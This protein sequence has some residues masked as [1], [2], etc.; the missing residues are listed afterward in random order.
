MW[1]H[2]HD[3]LANAGSLMATTV[4]TSGLGF[5]FWTFA[6]REFSQQAVGYGSAAV[7]AM[8]LLGTIGV[9]GLG[10]V[11]IGEL[12]R[13][14]P[15]AGL[16]SAALLTCGL[17]SVLLGIGFAMVAPLVSRRFGDMMGT[18]VQALLF[19]IGVALTAV[20]SV[21]D[22]ATIGLLRGGVQLARNL[23]FAAAKLLALPVAA[24]ILHDQFGIGISIS[25]VAGMAASLAASAIWLRIRGSPVLPR[26][27]WGVL[28]GLGKTAL[29]HNWLNLAIAVPPTL[30]PV[31]VTVVVSPTAN[32][33]FYVAWLLTGFLYAVPGN[34]ATVLFAV[35]AAEPHMISQK[36]RFAVKLSLLIGVPAMFAEFLG[37]HFVLSL[38]GIGYAQEATFPL[39]LLALAYLPT[40]PKT[41]YIAVCRAAGKVSR[42]AVVLTTFAA[43]ELIAAGVGGKVGG[44]KGLTVAIFAIVVIEGLVTTPAVLRSAS[45]RDRRRR[46][47][48]GT[49]A[50]IDSSAEEGGPDERRS[51]R[52]G[53]LK[54]Q[55]RPARCT[56]IRCVC[57]SVQD[58]PS[59]A[60]SP[61][62][63]RH[64]R[65]TGLP[66][67]A[68]LSQSITQTIPFPAIHPG[69]ALT[70]P[71]PAIRAWP[72]HHA[73]GLGPAEG[74]P[75]RG[76]APQPDR[77]PRS[78]D[79][80]PD[81][82]EVTPNASE[83][84]PDT[85]EV[86]PDT[87]EVTDVG[88]TI[89]TIDVLDHEPPA[90]PVPPPGGTGP[91]LATLVL[92]ALFGVS[93]LLVV[94]GYA[95]NAGGLRL[96]GVLG[97]LFLGVGT[98]PLQMS[99]RAR[100]DLRLAVAGVV[101]LS[102]STLVASVMVLLPLW[103]PLLAA[104]VI[105]VVAAGVH[106]YACRRALA[107]VS[108]T[109]LFRFLRRGRKL[110]D[111]SIICSLT[112][113]VLWCV[114]AL[115]R[116]HVVPG[117]L[118]FL[119]QISVL[120][121][122][123]LLLLL[124]GIVFGRGKTEIHAMFGL[125]SL[126]AALTLTPSLVYGTPRS[127]SAGKHID[128]VQLILQS[129]HL[130]R[131]AGIY[132]AYSGLF[133]AVAWLCDLAKVH[134]SIG[135]ATYW[136]FL[137]GLIGLAELRF[138]FGRLTSSNYRIWAAMTLVVLVNAIGADYFSPQSVGFAIGLGV[139]GLALGRQ[140]QGLDERVRMALLLLAG[141]ALAVTHELSPFIVGG[142]LA[143]L[144]VFRVIRPWY[145]PVTSLLPAIA[146]ALLNRH[147][148]S[149]FVSFADLGNLSNFAPPKTAATAN[150]QRLPIVGESSHA[151]LIGLLV[152]IVLAG[153]GFVRHIRER[154]T[155][156]FMISVGVGLF[157]IAANPYGNEG[158]FRAA[159][160]GIPW[161]AALALRGV[162][163]HP[164]RWVSGIFGATI[165]GLLA[166]FLVAMFGLDNA[167]VI[168]TADLQA[169]SIYQAKAPESSY[170]LP[171]PY[172]TVPASVTFPASY[173]SLVWP[174]FGRPAEVRADMP[175][176][177]DADALALQY[178]KYAEQNG[179]PTNQLYALWSPAA[180]DYS[181]DYGLE[182]L[183]QAEAWRRLLMTSPDWQV[184]Y[185]SDGTYLFRVA[186]SAHAQKEPSS[187]T[188][189]AGSPALRS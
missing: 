76:T 149:N 110:L 132:Q 23:A 84:T 25:W 175:H 77:P 160:F 121:Y 65:E 30:I 80:G 101:G 133:S 165:I 155:W 61:P 99:R 16:V 5:T 41:F 33:A 150:L 143:V 114:A 108:G 4:V 161:L 21:F 39:R 128:L 180:A 119:P 14:S 59:L 26:P 157:L 70:I 10:T 87:S 98:A 75:P 118:G 11:L 184:V 55:D 94:A 136:P 47:L 50:A 166:T 144:V 54:P 93:L 19:A 189:V 135:L 78:P 95:L 142:V 90:T 73:P 51:D 69:V 68:R 182:T 138:F 107:E 7:S 151:L 168:R 20:T 1:R 64:A 37:A 56:E 96:I 174:P 139:F 46:G 115:E 71:F 188:R 45:G 158:I 40:L 187:A 28:R 179:G 72:Q 49:R 24:V 52:T 18:P 120:W 22:N 129:H 13:R 43:I 148:L 116:G 141:C 122:I 86:T 112:G 58:C 48:A 97:A 79:Y 178:I 140:S 117:V 167:D 125:V 6:A 113:T 185:N 8:S 66:A 106:A 44:L 127:Q 53:N 164:G 130:N 105:G 12:P 27:D 15:R 123:G 67:L 170:I 147:V 131:G 181:V 38:F 162:P 163:R 183:A 92:T 177:G 102:T 29:A 32:A 154:E 156:A 176:A 88:E 134:D 159:L 126:V 81:A 124:A 3:L 173:H 36:L 103:H 169:F 31:L 152:L 145:V 91:E 153:V 171:L 137:M 85:S 89:E 35:A 109:E 100:L 60:I 111:A 172:G 146:W 82:S 2:H 186:M 83:V 57:T 9:F 62:G 17:G 34:L 74:R 63:D 104:A 42:A